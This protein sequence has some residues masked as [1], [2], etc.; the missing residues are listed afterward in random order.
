V[1]RAQEGKAA[2]AKSR[3]LMEGLI[4]DMQDGIA[5]RSVV[6]ER[7]ELEAAGAERRTLL[8]HTLSTL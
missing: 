4:A 5:S 8:Q 2:L 1:Q 6:I 3:L 7:L